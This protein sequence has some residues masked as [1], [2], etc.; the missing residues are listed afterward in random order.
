MPKYILLIE[1]DP[2]IL[3]LLD[4]ILEGEGYQT[5]SSNGDISTEEISSKRTPNSFGL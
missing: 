1:D 5:I 3:E 4:L 2:D